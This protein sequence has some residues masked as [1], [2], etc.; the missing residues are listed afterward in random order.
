MWYL[1]HGL[2]K[3]GVNSHVFCPQG[4]VL[5]E[6]LGN[7]HITTFHKRAGL[8]VNAAM[9]FASWCKYNDPDIIHAHDA[10]AHSIVMIAFSFFGAKCPV[11]LSRRVD[12]PLKKKWFTRWKYNHQGIHTI[13]CVSDAIK[14]I[15]ESSLYNKFIRV[16]T[17]HSGVDTNRF[18][19]EAK[20][21]WRKTLGLDP[22]HKLIGN[23][24]ALADH[25]DYF[26]F[27]KVADYLCGFRTDVDFII[28]GDGPL[29]KELMKA[30]GKLQHKERVHFVGFQE[31]LGSVYSALD[32]L[33]FTSKTEGLGTSILDAMAF[34]VPVVA[35]NTGG[36]PEIVQHGNS[37]LLA[38][39]GDFENL[40]KEVI[41]VLD[42]ADLAAK[43]ALGGRKMVHHFSVQNM[44]DKTLD[45]Y[46][47]IINK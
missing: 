20:T 8:D 30:H 11:V 2:Q 1:H 34:D 5:A 19:H 21:D 14:R 25:K 42:N 47:K 13:L 38:E 10:H 36:I 29:K 4:S 18:S 6:R 41:A 33:L 43:L 9:H 39:V 17:V 28:C 7:A 45:A 22:N 31:D 12:F 27:L 35:T 15:V 24:A 26:T 23:V 3:H 46:Q 44:V 32:V 16:T 37:G 40:A